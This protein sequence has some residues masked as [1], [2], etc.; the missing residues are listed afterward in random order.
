[1]ERAEDAFV[2]TQIYQDARMTYHI[3]NQPHSVVLDHIYTRI[4]TRLSHPDVPDFTDA[5]NMFSNTIARV[6][7]AFLNEK[8]RPCNFPE[9][10][11]YTVSSSRCFVI[12]Y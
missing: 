1:M 9:S 11:N 2:F 10:F 4:P 6:L 3:E 12:V 7:P 5:T 8:G